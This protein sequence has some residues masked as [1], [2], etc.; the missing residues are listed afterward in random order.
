L[1]GGRRIGDDG[2]YQGATILQP[3]AID[4]S[5]GSGGEGKPRG[6]VDAATRRRRF[7]DDRL[8][9]VQARPQ[10]GVVGPQRV[11]VPPR[12]SVGS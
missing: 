2:G 6:G 12:S 3:D 10:V 5:D 9:R 11:G 7:P 1:G 8:H 4:E